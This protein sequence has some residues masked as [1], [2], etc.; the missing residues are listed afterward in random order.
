VPLA[1]GLLT[2]KLQRDSTFAAD[3]HR[4]FNRQEKPSTLNIFGVDYE[5]G[6]A[7]VEGF[8]SC[9]TGVSMSQFALRWI[10]M[11]DAVTYAIPGASAWG[12][13]PITAMLRPSPLSSETMAA[14]RRIYMR[15]FGH[16]CMIVVNGAAG[17]LAL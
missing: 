10:L 16:W 2:S 5:V 15:R 17:G 14:V 8:D 1:S 12:R 9:T 6:L 3:D 4:N 7:A 13:F 11:F